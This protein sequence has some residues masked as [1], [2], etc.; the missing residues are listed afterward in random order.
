M[1]SGTVNEKVGVAKHASATGLVPNQ[2]G[3]WGLVFQ[4]LG[5]I[6]PIGIFFAL[7]GTAEFVQGAMALVFLVGFVGVLMSANTLFWYSRKIANARGYY[8]YVKDGLGRHAATFTAYSYV[9]YAASNAA[10][11][12]LF[13]LVGFSGSINLVFHTNFPWWAGI[14]FA[15]S[16]LAVVFY[17]MWS[18][19]KP[20]IKAM[21]ALGVLQMIVLT[22]ISLIF[23]AK[24]P[25]NSVKPFAPYTG[26]SG[27]FLGFVTGGYLAYGGYGSIVSLGEETKAPNK[28]VGKALITIL[29]IGAFAWVIASYATAVA[30]GLGNMKSFVTAEVPAA[31]LT[32]RY[33]GVGATAIMTL[34]YDLVIYT[35]LNNFLTS[36]SRVVFAMG[37]DRLL[38]A[39]LAKVNPKRGVPVAGIA[40]I[41]GITILLAAVSTAV[42]VAMYGVPNGI[43]DS[44]I[45][46]G[47]LTTLLAL[48]VH[49]MASLS[50]I[51][52]GLRKRFGQLNAKRILLLVLIPIASIILTVAAIYYAVLGI[53]F[54]F[55]AAPIVFVLF[56][57]VLIVVLALR[58][59]RIPALEAIGE[60]E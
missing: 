1:S 22:V 20:S 32:N 39:S 27:L 19:L 34:L 24:A 12:I 2:V 54:P 37:R 58:R 36:G 29:V 46:L 42:L 18:G 49:G 52:S 43:I 14:I 25:D 47:I 48:L 59:D 38:P 45:V 57:I 60:T 7:I 9:L 23:I 41:T 8:G 15:G 53:T 17:G 4:G 40:V 31:I 3:F 6:A 10:G 13:Y 44:Y 33:I 5:G 50:I 51:W 26:V 11:L 35:L 55:E 16:G 56:C 30:W 28:T 21:I